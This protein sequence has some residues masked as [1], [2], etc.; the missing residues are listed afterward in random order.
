MPTTYVCE[1]CH[2]TS[3][4]LDG[5]LIVSVQF[6]HLDP[7]APFPPGGRM[8]DSTAPDLLFDK[9][10]CREAWCARADL[11][12]PGLP[13]SRSPATSPSTPLSSGG[14]GETS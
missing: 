7:A 6:I 9:L 13:L 14:R 8:L 10:A 1:T 4:S 5:W 3:P 2:A 11:A 12:D